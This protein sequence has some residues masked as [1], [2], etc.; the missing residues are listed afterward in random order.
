MRSHV[1]QYRIED[2]LGRGGMGVVYRGVHEHLGRPVAIKALVPELT[3]QPEFKERFFAEAKTQARLQHPNIVG[4]YDLLEEGGEFF[5]VMEF[6]AGQG[7]DDRFCAA[8]GR[9]MELGAA[10]GVARQVLAALD[11]AHSQGVVHRDVKPSNVLVTAGG[12]VKFTDFG[13]A[14]LVGDKRLTSSQSTIG[15]PTYMSPEQIL[16]PRSVDHR[17]DIYSAAVVFFEMLAGRPPFDDETEYGI[18][19][20]HVET[21][22][23]LS[24]LQPSLPPALVA[25]IARALE[26]DPEDRYASAGL[27]LQAIEQAVPGPVTMAAPPTVPSYRPTTL[28]PPMAGGARPVPPPGARSQGLAAALSRLPGGGLPWL[29]GAG[30]ALVLAVGVG[31]ALLI[32]GPPTQVDPGEPTEQTSDGVSAG[33]SLLATGGNLAV[34]EAGDPKAGLRPAAGEPTTAVPLSIVEPPAPRQPAPRQIEQPRP[35]AA[36]PATERKPPAAAPAAAPSPAPEPEPEAVTADA[37]EP[38]T[39]TIADAAEASA[40]IDQFADIEE[41]L[42]NLVHL[43]EKAYDAHESEAGGNALIDRLHAFHE[44]TAQVQKVFKRVT[45]TGTLSSVRKRWGKLRGNKETTVRELEIEIEEMNRRAAAVDGLIESQT[46]GPK[47]LALWQ[48]VRQNL[49]RLR[50]LT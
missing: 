38:E 12:Q 42:K 31:F 46:P 6:V 37:A 17:T 48:E 23:D 19:K 24:L 8:P 35:A 1:G 26:K 43:S 50:A 29:V 11:Y 49:T 9:A 36:K 25:A 4:V 10:I 45:G 33:E 30:A 39:T 44:S 22:P 47:T 16:R 3:Q 21:P 32:A 41:T 7:L 20:Q 34:T 28:E 40:G 15:T 13:I 2:L 5:I 18:K 27:F 14:L